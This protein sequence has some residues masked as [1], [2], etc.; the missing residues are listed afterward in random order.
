MG[1]LLQ[2]FGLAGADNN[3]FRSDYKEPV[4]DETMTPRADF[5]TLK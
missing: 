4:Y 1:G 2:E 5:F 3:K